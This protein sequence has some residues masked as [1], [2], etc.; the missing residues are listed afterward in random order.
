MGAAVLLEQMA[1]AHVGAGGGLLY[2]S[3]HPDCAL[4]EVLRQAAQ[5]APHQPQF[6]SLAPPNEKGVQ[7]CAPRLDAL[8]QSG[9]LLHLAPGATQSF[10][11][12][13]AGTCLLLRQLGA[14]LAARQGFERR[15]LLVVL[16][17]ARFDMSGLALLRQGRALG[18][19]FVLQAD[20]PAQLERLGPVF[21][22][23]VLAN[24]GTQLVLAP[25]DACEVEHMA[26]YLAAHSPLQM[27]QARAALEALDAMG[28][29]AALRLVDG[30]LGAVRFDGSHP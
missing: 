8:A 4:D 18:L 15:P 28:P 2:V 7:T 10:S 17:A 3:D 24:V 13:H 26:G 19:T 16:P 20:T 12:A 6:L 30:Q 29:G 9:Y 14:V 22:S 21:A 11:A 5:Q 27:E 1:L 25:A 23:T